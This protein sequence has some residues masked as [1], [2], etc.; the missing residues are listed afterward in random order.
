MPLERYDHYHKNF[1]APIPGA[2]FTPN[3][4]VLEDTIG[5]GDLANPIYF[6][7]VLSCLAI[8]VMTDV[9]RVYGAHITVGDSDDDLDRIFTQLNQ[10]VRGAGNPIAVYILGFVTGWKDGVSAAHYKWP[11]GMKKKMKIFGRGLPLYRFEKAQLND[12]HVYRGAY[13]AG[14]PPSMIWSFN[15]TANP[16]TSAADVTGGPFAAIP[17]HMFVPYTI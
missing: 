12:R 10:H 6:P 1:Q 17:N 8:A 3:N 2:W 9:N 7:N 11:D 13:I 14:A 5:M 16:Q 4:F 15:Q